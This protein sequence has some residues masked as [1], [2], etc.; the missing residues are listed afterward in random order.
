MQSPD[1]KMRK[2]G[3]AILGIIAEGCADA[4]RQMLPSIMPHLIAAAGDAEQGVKETAFF[5]LGKY[6]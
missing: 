3:C 1:P 4:V 5:A 6:E 2:A